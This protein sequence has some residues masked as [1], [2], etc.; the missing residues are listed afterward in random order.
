MAASPIGNVSELTILIIQYLRKDLETLHSCILVNRLFCRI[1]IPILWENPF[2]VKCRRGHRYNFFDIYFSY[3]ND[4]DKTSLSDIGIKINPSPFIKP[5]FNYPSFINTLSI[6]RLELHT[7]NLIYDFS[8][9]NSHEFTFN[10]LREGIEARYSTFPVLKL[11]PSGSKN[12][13]IYSLLFKLFMNS[14]ASLKKFSLFFKNSSVIFLTSEIYNM[15]LN[16]ENFISNVDKLDLWIEKRQ[17]LPT[18]FLATL[19]S[20][21]PSIKHLSICANTNNT[22]NLFIRNLIQSQ[23]QLLS[24]SLYGMYSIVLLDSFKCYFNTLTLIKFDNCNFANLGEYDALKN[25]TQLKSLHFNNWK[26]IT[27]PFL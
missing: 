21:I 2:S 18:R 14:N 20:L 16:N 27:P 13:L 4:E 1:T 7:D 25:L 3:L 26:G 15:M 22:I 5:L 9:S 24:L 8:K 6:L 17:T 12:K 19:P 10:S 23:A 11:H